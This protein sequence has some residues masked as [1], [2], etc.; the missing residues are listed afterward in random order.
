[1]VANLNSLVRGTVEIALLIEG[2]LPCGGVQAVELLEQDGWTLNAQGDA[3]K[4]FF[5]ARIADL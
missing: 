5:I 1:M 4:V 2:N 3:C